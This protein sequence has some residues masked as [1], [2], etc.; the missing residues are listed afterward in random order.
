LLLRDYYDFQETCKRQKLEKQQ[1]LVLMQQQQLQAVQVSQ[2]PTQQGPAAQ[3]MQQSLSQ[4]QH[5]PAAEV[6]S[7]VDVE[8]I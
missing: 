1:G 2:Q 7:G 3:M 5:V 6:A 8:E 4:V